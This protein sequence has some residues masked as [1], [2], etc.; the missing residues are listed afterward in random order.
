MIYTRHQPME[1]MTVWLKWVFNLIYVAEV[2]GLVTVE[3]KIN[4]L[5]GWYIY[6]ICCMEKLCL[7]FADMIVTP[8]GIIKE[9]L[10]KNYRLDPSRFL[11]VT[12]G[13][14]PDVFR[15]MD[16][17]KSRE[18][19]GFNAQ[20][21]FLV[22]VGSLKKWHGIEKIVGIMPDILKKDPA[23]RLIIVGDGDKMDESIA[24]VKNLKLENEVVLTGRVP[25]EDV[26]CYINAGD[27]CLAPYF[28]PDIDETGISPLK[29]YEYL[30]CARPVI[31]NPVGGLDSLFDEYEAGILIG[32]RIPLDW[33][34]PIVKLLHDPAQLAFYGANGR[35]A[36]INKFSWEAVCKNISNS[37][38]DLLA[39]K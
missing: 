22:F 30:A 38:Q 24:I 13:A 35:T 5:P 27:V 23:I 39:N 12:N 20:D 11:A 28:D 18:K 36:V 29:I 9:S 10:C 37:L 21:K 3:M 16:K 6:I 31:T 26:P 32:S 14:D 19:F 25:F 1:W 7:N 33:V 15:P 34:E 2:N 17:I 4:R 8:S